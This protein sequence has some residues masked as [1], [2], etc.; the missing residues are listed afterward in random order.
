[1]T[2]VRGVPLSTEAG[3]LDYNS[4]AVSDVRGMD[5]CLLRMRFGKVITDE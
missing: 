3:I 1:M 2:T 5:E 4:E